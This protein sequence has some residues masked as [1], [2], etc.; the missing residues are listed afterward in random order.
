PLV[1]SEVQRLVG[2]HVSSIIISDEVGCEKP[3]RCI[4]ECAAES[5]KLS[6]AECIHIGDDF[7]IDAIGAQRNGGFAAGVWLNGR[8][9]RPCPRRLNGVWEIKKLIEVMSLLRRPRSAF[10]DS[11]RMGRTRW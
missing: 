3:E 1:K 2:S 8:E 4:F 7:E 9:N 11:R 6:P 10:F 5:L